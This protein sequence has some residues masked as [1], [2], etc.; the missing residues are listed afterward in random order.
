MTTSISQPPTMSRAIAAAYLAGMPVSEIARVLKRGHERVSA[1]IKEALSTD[2]LPGSHRRPDE[3]AD[4]IARF[5]PLLAAVSHGNQ[6]PFP[7][8]PLPSGDPEPEPDEPDYVP[9]APE[10][11]IRVFTRPDG[12]SIPHIPS[13]HGGQHA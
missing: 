1:A 8:P 4:A 3:R 10:L 9:L 11:G 13:I 6:P 7:I 2:K 12:I 5:S